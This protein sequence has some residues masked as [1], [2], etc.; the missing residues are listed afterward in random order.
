LRTTF[1]NIHGSASTFLCGLPFANKAGMALIPTK[2]FLTKGVG[3]HEKSLRAF[4]N[5]LRAAGINQCNLVKVSSIIAPGCKL[6]SREEGMKQIKPGQVTF[7]VMATSETNEPGQCV[8]AG[9][10]MA[11]PKDETL[12][13]YLTEVEEA[14]G[15]TDQDVEQ[16]VVEMALEN[17]VS[18]WNPKFEGENAYRKGQK[19]YHLEGRDIR[20]ESIVQSAEGAEKNQYT[21]VIVAAVFV[22][23]DEQP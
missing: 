8:V 1:S 2:F 22:Y 12:Y 3:V 6:V 16:D 9:I 23:E 11:Q 5:A 14:I 13:G 21:C 20:V 17:L 15:R 7:A 10:G 4:E 19:N 18:E